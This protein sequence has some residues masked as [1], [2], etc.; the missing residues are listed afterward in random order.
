MRIC[1]I[2]DCDNAIYAKGY[3]NKHYQR[4][5]RNGIL[6]IKHRNPI[7]PMSEADIAWLAG[8]LEG[9]GSFFMAGD[10]VYQYPTIVVSMTDLDVIERV[11]RLFGVSVYPQKL[12]K[13]YPNGKRAYRTQTTGHKAARLMELLLPWM[14]DRR[15]AKIKELLNQSNARR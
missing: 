11:A 13:R 6:E 14:G 5:N 10:D 7:L 9:E 2:A 8:L 4:F 1:N 3:C 15:A 12:D